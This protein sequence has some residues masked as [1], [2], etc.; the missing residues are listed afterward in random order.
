MA[1]QIKAWTTFFNS[2]FFYHYLINQFQ[3]VFF[4]IIDT[5]YL[6]GHGSHVEL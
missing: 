5:I 3:V 1:M 6:D 4:N 2:K